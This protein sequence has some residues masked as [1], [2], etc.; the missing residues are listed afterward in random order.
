MGTALEMYST[1]FDGRYPRHLGKLT[2]NYLKTIPQCP[3]SKHQTYRMATGPG[4][5]YN[6]AGFKD[7]YFLE[8]TGNS[9]AKVGVSRNYPQYDGIQGLIE[10]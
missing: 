3:Q 2:P 10:R 8:C 7:Y 4:M 9:H 6:T 1:D 5:A